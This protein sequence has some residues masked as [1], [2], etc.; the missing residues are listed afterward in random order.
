MR[1]ELVDP[2]LA[3][4]FDIAECP[5]V[6]HPSD[7]RVA[8]G[9]RIHDEQMSV[10]D[11]AA[12][13]ATVGKLAGDESPHDVEALHDAVLGER[14]ALANHRC[15]SIACDDEV[16]V[17]FARTVV[18]VGMNAYYAIFLIDEIAHGDAALELE[19]GKFRRF[20]DNHLKHRGLRD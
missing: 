19:V 13:G 9:G 6:Y 14:G 12:R 20:G 16:T 8:F 2:S 17:I 4:P 11:V 18:R 5:L 7:L 3:H 10:S 1:R 15:A